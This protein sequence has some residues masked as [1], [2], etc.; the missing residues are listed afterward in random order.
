[1]SYLN[2]GASIGGDRVGT[3]KVLRETMR[4]DPSL[5]T[6]DRTSEMGPDA[7]WTFTGDQ[8]PPGLTLS[9]VG[10]DPYRRRSWYATVSPTGRVS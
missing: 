4:L 3:K 6:F 9:V 7:P 8:L 2:V 10:P 1:M 5:V